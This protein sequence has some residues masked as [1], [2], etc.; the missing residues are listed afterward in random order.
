M[1]EPIQNS[2]ITFVYK[3]VE[4]LLDTLNDAIVTIFCL[5]D[6][7]TKY[8]GDKKEVLT[9]LKN[10]PLQPTNIPAR[11]IEVIHQKI[12]S[13]YVL[14]I[15]DM[16]DEYD[17]IAYSDIDV[18]TI[19]PI[20]VLIKLVT[21]RQTQ[22]E[23]WLVKSEFKIFSVGYEDILKI[24]GAQTVIDMMKPDFPKMVQITSKLNQVHSV[25]E[26]LK[27]AFEKVD[28][29]VDQRAQAIHKLSA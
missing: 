9:K 12:Q 11:L 10:H 19:W 3:I 24:G 26:D 23:K 27:N 4:S 2:K 16:E 13:D 25:L 17:P 15:T 22:F 21:D 1:L 20:R 8:T 14:M 18:K 5:N 7:T 29:K 6:K 28:E